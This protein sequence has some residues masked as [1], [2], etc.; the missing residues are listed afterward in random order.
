MITNGNILPP[1][2]PQKFYCKKC[3]VKCF[4]KSHF[5]EHLETIKHKTAEMVTNDNIFPPFPP[6][7]PFSEN[8]VL[9]N[10]KCSCGRK[11]KYYSGLSRHKKTCG[12]E[13]SLSSQVINN[14]NPHNNLN[15]VI[16]K[17]FVMQ[18]M[19]ENTEQFKDIILE[20]CKTNTN[21]TQTNLNSYTNNVNSHNKTFNLNLFLNEQCKDALNLTDFVDS[22]KLE[23]SD[24]ENV[25][26]VG[27]VNGITNIFLKNLKKLDVCKRPVHC[28]DAKREVMYVKDENKWEKENDEKKRLKNAIRCIANKNTKM[29]PVF[30]EKYPDCSKSESKQSDQY[31][32]LIIE[33]YGGI[34]T[35]D[36]D[37]ENKIIK[38]IAKEV[39]I[40][41]DSLCI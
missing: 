19:K 15:N 3:D 4:K 14:I 30:R 6:F 26:R 41:K 39:V 12:S 8:D 23:L 2:P 13:L 27:F 21:L 9:Q 18:L 16:D 35:S 1:F 37:N 34:G 11:Y 7:P 28:S 25:G 10:H 24:L 40:N 20:V 38:N 5:V 22:I 32:K 33:T 36:S 29:L 31:N 17:D